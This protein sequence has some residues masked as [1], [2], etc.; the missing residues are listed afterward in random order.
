MVR[1]PRLEHVDACEPLDRSW[2]YPTICYHY[3]EG[4][5][6]RYAVAVGEYSEGVAGLQDGRQRVLKFAQEQ[7]RAFLDS[8]GG[9]VD[10]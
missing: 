7:R 10:T 2:R 4:S 6:V 3:R 9:N 1:M 8:L 5:R